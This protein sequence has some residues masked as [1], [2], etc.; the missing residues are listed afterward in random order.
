MIPYEAQLI[1]RAETAL[2]EERIREATRRDNHE[3]EPY[4]ASPKQ[5]EGNGS[6]KPTRR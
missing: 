2:F 5:S 6:A 1:A 3:P 4:V